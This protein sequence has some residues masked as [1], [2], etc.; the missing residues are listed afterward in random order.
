MHIHS[1]QRYLE[2]LS[3][4]ITDLDDEIRDHVQALL[5]EFSSNLEAT[6]SALDESVNTRI[7]NM[8]ET[9][10]AEM[11]ALDDDVNERVQSLTD[12]IDQ[13]VEELVEWV[14]EQSFSDHVW[15]VTRGT[16]TDS[17][18]GMRRLFYD[19]T[20]HGTT[21]EQLA[22]TDRYPTVSDLATSGWNVRALAVI[23]AIVLDHTTD[24]SPWQAGPLHDGEVLDPVA[25][26]QALIDDDGF[27]VVNDNPLNT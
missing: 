19:V 4:E 15:D 25:L 6:I 22:E 5:D 20:V 2:Y 12:Y 21:V 13:T 26:S 9:T 16:L 3:S 24:P 7:S 8:E 18:D 11:Q 14:Q 1:V 17:V 27:V 23:G 10:Q